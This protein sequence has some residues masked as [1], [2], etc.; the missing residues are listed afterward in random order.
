MTA[1]TNPRWAAKVR[2]LHDRHVRELR[3]EGLTEL[4]DVI[5]AVDEGPRDLGSDGGSLLNTGET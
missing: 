4:A 3:E 5:E 2:A 1:Q